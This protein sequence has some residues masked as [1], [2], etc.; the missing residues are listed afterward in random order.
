MFAIFFGAGNFVFPPIIGV[1][2]GSAWKTAIV[3]LTLSGIILPILTIIAMDNMGGDHEHLFA[4]VAPWFFTAFSIAFIIMMLTIGPPRQAA[5]AIE[6]GI[7]SIFPGLIGNNVVRVILLAVYFILVQY[8]SINPAKIVDI[9]GKMLTP[10]LLVALAIIVFIGIVHPI[11]VPAA[12]KEDN[13]FVYSFT[14]AYQTGDVCV[15]ISMVATFIAS[16][17]VKGY[18]EPKSRRSM[19]LLSALVALICLL[20]VYGGLLYLGASGSA[21]YPA[22]IDP[23]VLLI[24]LINSVSGRFGNIVLGIGIFFAC[25]TS[26]IGM[27]TIMSQFS[28]TISRGKLEYKKC[29]LV[30]NILSFLMACLGV[31]NIIRYTYAIFVLIYPVAIAVT[32]L[33][34]CKRIVPNHGAWKGAVLMAGIVAL[35]EAVVTLNDSGIT[36]IHIAPLEKLYSLLPLSSHGIG[37]LVPALIGLVVGAVI[38]ALRKGEAYP[39][40]EE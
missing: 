6:T 30:Y 25:L 34:T 37:W 23:S 4:P 3:G 26:S 15:G 14:Q 21:S 13:I 7:F 40:L 29:L 18:T 20:I 33:G 17:K 32:L 36:N 27:Q 1:V 11:G 28:V 35:Y 24:S 31:A 16:V 2:A 8:F 19:I 22:D 12:P 39:M 38:V 5:V 9:V 10:F